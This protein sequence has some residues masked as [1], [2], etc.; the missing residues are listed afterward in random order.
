MFTFWT[1]LLLQK[2]TKWIQEK[3]QNEGH[4]H[5]F[6]WVKP[7]QHLWIRQQTN[8]R[9]ANLLQDL[10][11]SSEIQWDSEKNRTDTHMGDYWYGASWEKTYFLSKLRW[12]TTNLKGGYKYK[13]FF[14]ISVSKKEENE[15]R[16]HKP[17]GVALFAAWT[18]PS[19]STDQPLQASSDRVKLVGRPSIRP[20]K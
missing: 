17:R 16:L 4:E 14:C 5:F 15:I 3:N 12:L 10:F 19:P 9:A 1:S 13:T 20:P 18:V 8:K 11:P 2:F 7:D 6:E